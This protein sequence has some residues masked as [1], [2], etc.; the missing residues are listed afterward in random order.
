MIPNVQPKTIAIA[1]NATVPISITG[2]TIL[3]ISSVGSFQWS[4]DG[5]PY[6]PGLTIMG[7]DISRGVNLLGSVSKPIVVAPQF[8]EVLL[9]DTSG[10]ANSV[11]FI[12]ANYP[13]TYI[14][15]I[16]TTISKDAPTYSKGSGIIALAGGG[17]TLY[18]GVD[19]VTGKLRKQIIVTNADANN[20]S[21]YVLDVNGNVGLIIPAGQAETLPTGSSYTVKNPNGVALNPGYCVMELFYL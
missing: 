12:V 2:S 18:N 10:A 4:L 20:N 21:I 8:T 14:N 3:F 13:V 19:A 9:Q 6:Q 5:G 7:V 1:A 15:P 17:T 11:T 16:P